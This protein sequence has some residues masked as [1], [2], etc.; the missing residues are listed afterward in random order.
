MTVSLLVLWL[1]GLL[2]LGLF[3]LAVMVAFTSFGLW[4]L[5]SVGT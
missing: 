2:G 3:T 5:S 1:A 4:L